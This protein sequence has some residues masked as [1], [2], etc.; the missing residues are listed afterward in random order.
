VGLVDDPPVDW[1]MSQVE[2]QW[3]LS[4]AESVAPR[5]AV[6]V[7]AGGSTLALARY[8]KRVTSIDKRRHPALRAAAPRNVRLWHGKSRWLLPLAMRLPGVDLVLIDGDHNFLGAR[9]D[10]NDVLRFR[11]DGD[12]LLVMHDVSNEQCRA[13][14]EAAEWSSCPWIVDIDLDVIE[15]DTGWGGIGVARLHG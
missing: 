12:R 7:G 8:S 3:L 13:G 11:P 15:S 14:I 4:T 5:R 10:V 9:D 6:E 2:R 1:L